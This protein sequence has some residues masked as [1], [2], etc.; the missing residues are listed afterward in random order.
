[1]A[2]KKDKIFGKLTEPLVVQDGAVT[3][4]IS[5][6]D[7]S[8]DG[9][10]LVELERAA[11]LLLEVLIPKVSEFAKEVADIVLKIPRW[12]LL[13]GSLLAQYEVGRLASPSIDPSWRSG[14]PLVVTKICEHCHTQFS[15]VKLRQRYCSNACGTLAQ[16]SK[17]RNPRE[18]IL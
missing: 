2:M 7:A 13:L 6:T 3:D 9:L 14:R 4:D 17:D 11:N 15:P 18:V 8:E 1:M 12:Q 10:K 5:A 16:R